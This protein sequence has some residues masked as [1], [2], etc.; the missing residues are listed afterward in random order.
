VRAGKFSADG[1]WLAI[2][3]TEA[4]GVWDL[5]RSAPVKVLTDAGIGGAFFNAPA[6]E[7]FTRS[8]QKL[9]RYRL[10]PG[11]NQNAPP[12]LTPLPVLK[13]K[14]E[15][16]SAEILEFQSALLTTSGDG[17]HFVPLTNVASSDGR[18]IKGSF[19]RV[20]V[21]A[22][23]TRLAAASPK[24]SVLRLFRLPDMTLERTL[25]NSAP[26][27]FLTFAA[28][29]RAL[30]VLTDQ[31]V[32]LWDTTDWRITHTRPVTVDNVSQLTCAPDGRVLLLRENSR[33]GALLDARTLDVL[34]PFPLWNYPLALSADGRQLA[35]GV[36]GRHVR[37]WDFAAVRAHF[38]ALGIDW[39]P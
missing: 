39:E 18:L 14:P 15:V 31:E 35:V 13:L 21:T 26:V 7:L 30:A 23:E 16:R 6:D 24:Q 12:V 2:P 19:W 29:G 32:C 36:D 33:T 1:R 22:D 20:A 4:C 17:L 9:F 10:A 11:T 34:L 5:T 25:T 27:R 38:Q 28:N 8:D 3:T 37:L